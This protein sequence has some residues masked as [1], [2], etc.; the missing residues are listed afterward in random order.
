[1]KNKVAIAVIVAAV[2][3]GVVSYIILSPK[4]YSSENFAMDTV[5]NMNI[6]GKDP[7]DT[8]AKI[9]ERI[10]SFDSEYSMFRPSSTITKIN[11]ASGKNPVKVSDE[12][13]ALMKKAYSL[14][15]Q[16]DG[17]FDITIAPLVF[18]WNITGS[19][20]K[21][22]EIDPAILSLIDYKGIKFNDEQKTIMLETKGQ[23]IDLGGLLKGSACDEI[24]SVLNSSDTKSAIVS[25]GGNVV[26]HGD[27]IY[28]VGIKHP[29]Q[30]NS[31]IATVKLSNK[32]VSTTGDYERYFE[33]D[34]KR[35]HHIFD[36]ATG[37]PHES[38]FYSV[39]VIGEDG[40]TGDFLSTYMFLSDTKTVIS[41]LDK[42][43]IIAFG[44][45]NKVYYSSGLDIELLD[46]NFTKYDGK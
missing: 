8:G 24:K 28:K 13:Y 21:V 22:P 37:Y 20:P 44:K 19:N 18:M 40:M 4:T 11:D 14:C 15:E 12:G 10:Y 9:I 26:L 34:G 35:Y 42:Y 30:N 43:D 5:I 46:N 32:V 29:R 41:M 38:D 17:K 36:K 27:G 7:Q 39:T 45:D 25:L 2:A 6:T 1:M 31:M 3:I 23:Q 16:S 33:I